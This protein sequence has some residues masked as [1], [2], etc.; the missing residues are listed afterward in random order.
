MADKALDLDLRIE[1]T[2]ARLSAYLGLPP[3][4]LNIVAVSSTEAWY[5]RRA[6]DRERLVASGLPALEN[7]I[8]TT[9]VAQAGLR[10]LRA[11]VGTLT[12]LTGD[13]SAPIASEL[14]ALVGP[15]E[16]AK[17]LAELDANER[18]ALA[19]GDDLADR[20]QLERDFAARVSG[21]EQ[22]FCDRVDLALRDIRAALAEDAEPMTPEALA[23]LARTAA[24]AGPKAFAALRHGAVA[25][26][27]DWERRTAQPLRVLVLNPQDGLAL[28][29]PP[30]SVRQPIEFTPAVTGGAQGAVALSATLAPVGGLIGTLFAG[31]GAVVGAAIGGL[32]GQVVGFFGGFIEQV[33]RT[34]AKA[35]VR[36]LRRYADQLLACLTDY[37]S[38]TLA[39]IEDTQQEILQHLKLQMRTLNRAQLSTIGQARLRV[40][41]SARAGAD[42]K[43]ARAIE[44]QRQRDVVAG[45]AARLYEVG[46]QLSTVEAGI[47]SHA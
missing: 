21:V 4:E 19:V 16:L 12:R 38:D 3:E 41:E 42:R 34:N 35:R 22:G 17:V 6:G 27:N 31:L 32:I 18:A 1:A 47:R 45:H 9:L 36:L 14:A 26:A 20:G 39:R 30:G 23:K 8:W 40:Q 29:G 46:Q 44:L 15:D 5:A 13:A 28:P 7:E 24:D 33:R 10:R 37:R 43:A 25:V 2:R 11:A